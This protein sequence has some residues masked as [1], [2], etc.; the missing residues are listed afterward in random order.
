M[1]V[2]NEPPLVVQGFPRVKQ[3]SQV[4]TEPPLVVLLTS[5]MLYGPI[6]GN[7]ILGVRPLS[8]DFGQAKLARSGL[9]SELALSAEGPSMRSALSDELASRYERQLMVVISD[10]GLS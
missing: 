6:Y 7:D 8:D 5:F 1:Q 9:S 3:G 4:W 10:G 2:W